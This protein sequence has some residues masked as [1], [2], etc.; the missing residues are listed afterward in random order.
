MIGPPTEEAR[1]SNLSVVSFCGRADESATQSILFA[2]GPADDRTLRPVHGDAGVCT[3]DHW[4][5]AA[6]VVTVPSPQ[7]RS[8]RSAPAATGGVRRGEVLRLSDPDRA[9]LRAGHTAYASV[10]S[11]TIAQAGIAAR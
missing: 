10:V 3:F 1:A 6:E 4:D 11:A 5:I 7:V 8:K 9:F 2:L